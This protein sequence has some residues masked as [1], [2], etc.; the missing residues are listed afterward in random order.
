[1]VDRWA[2]DEATILKRG[3]RGKY[4]IYYKFGKLLTC[5]MSV[6]TYLRNDKRL[7]MLL[8]LLYGRWAGGYPEKSLRA[9]ETW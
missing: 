2:C 4:M 5:C 8:L 1:M 3:K 7:L 9:V 6:I